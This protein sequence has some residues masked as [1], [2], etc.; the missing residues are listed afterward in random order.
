MKALSNSPYLLRKA[1]PLLNLTKMGIRRAFTKE[2]ELTV[3]RGQRVS[4]F[5]RLI[6]MSMLPGISD[7]L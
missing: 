1:T 3:L 7:H 2:I 5:P 4:K 6:C